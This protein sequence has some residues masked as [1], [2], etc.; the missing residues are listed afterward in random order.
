MKFSRRHFITAAA[1]ASLASGLNAESQEAETK[2]QNHKREKTEQMV[3]GKRPAIICK[4][5][6]TQGMDA[7]YDML[8]RGA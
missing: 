4:V 2:A 7:G 6:G 1:S 5:T 3:T 8:R